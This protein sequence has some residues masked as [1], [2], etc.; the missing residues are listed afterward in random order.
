MLQAKQRFTLVLQALDKCNL[1]C[2]C[3]LCTLS[4]CL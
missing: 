2:C 4:Y 3:Y 1:L